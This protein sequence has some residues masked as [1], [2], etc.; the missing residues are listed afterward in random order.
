MVEQLR[1]LSAAQVPGDTHRNLQIHPQF[2][3]RTFKHIL[4]PVWVLSFNYRA[5]LFQVLVN[6]YSGK[7]AG[8]YPLSWWKIFFLTV[9]VIIVALIVITLSEQ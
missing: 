6:G 4:V 8:D 9:V 2:S 1:Q 3:G 7:I 5:K